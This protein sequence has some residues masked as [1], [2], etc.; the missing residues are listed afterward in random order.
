VE[1][2]R[3]DFDGGPLKLTGGLDYGPLDII[4]LVL[5][6]MYLASARN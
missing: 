6:L 2:K 3:G 5:Q 1:E 4:G